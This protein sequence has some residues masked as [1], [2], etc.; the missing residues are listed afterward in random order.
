MAAHVF[1]EDVTIAGIQDARQIWEQGV[2]RDRLARWHGRNVD[3]AFYGWCDTWLHPGFRAWNI[4]AALPAVRVPV[5]V[6]QGEADQYGTP[7]QV[8]AIARQVSGPA[9]AMLLPGAGHAPHVDAPDAVVGAITR[10]VSGLA[11]REGR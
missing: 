6:M 10:F 2:L 3:G 5:L 4:E 8:H 11:A 1:V 7:A 9:E